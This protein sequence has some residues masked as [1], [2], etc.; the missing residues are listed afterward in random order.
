MKISEIAKLEANKNEQDRFVILFDI[1]CM[2]FFAINKV[3]Y[4]QYFNSDPRKVCIGNLTEC[5]V[6]TAIGR[7]KVLVNFAAKENEVTICG[8]EPWLGNDPFF[9]DAVIQNV[10]GDG[11]FTF[12]QAWKISSR[13]K[14]GRGA[15]IFS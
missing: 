1:E 8:G 9:S 5:I 7:V 2:D 13:E 6:K 12:E 10:A 11:F 14:S 4:E 15:C 3:Y